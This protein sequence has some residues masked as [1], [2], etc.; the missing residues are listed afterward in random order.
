MLVTPRGTCILF[1][2]EI[3]AKHLPLAATHMAIESSGAREA[4][5]THPTFVLALMFRADAIEKLWRWWW[6]RFWNAVA[7][8]FLE[9]AWVDVLNHLVE[10][11]VFFDARNTHGCPECW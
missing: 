11:L 1:S 4:A 8:N 9:D 5:L 2:A 3:T 10:L 7:L 6:R